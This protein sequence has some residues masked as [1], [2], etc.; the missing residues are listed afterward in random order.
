M[1]GRMRSEPHKEKGRAR[2]IRERQS[3][4]KN[5]ASPVTMK[6][7]GGGGGG[8]GLRAKSPSTNYIGKGKKVVPYAVALPSAIT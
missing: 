4:K 8:G 7:R 3:I 6:R 2:S 5:Q 1:S